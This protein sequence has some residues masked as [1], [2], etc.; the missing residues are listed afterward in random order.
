M[1]VPKPGGVVSNATR[2]KRGGGTDR[3]RRDWALHHGVELLVGSEDEEAI[4]C[5]TG[6]V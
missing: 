1:R 6:E 3:S 5:C 2:P 4:W